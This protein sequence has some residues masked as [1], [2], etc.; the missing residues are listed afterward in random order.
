M[1][2]NFD[3]ILKNLSSI[4]LEKKLKISL[5][6]SCTGGLISKIFTDYSGSSEWFL[7]AIIAYNNDLKTLLGV[8][9]M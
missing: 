2:I 9:H 4:L 3:M 6:E 1:T 5:C 7:G 8:N